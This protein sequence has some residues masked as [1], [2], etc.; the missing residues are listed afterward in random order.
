MNLYEFDAAIDAHRRKWE[1][2]RYIAKR[3]VLSGKDK[4]AVIGY[5]LLDAQGREVMS[6]AWTSGIAESLR[7]E[8]EWER[9]SYTWLDRLRENA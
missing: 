5:T 9:A 4:D 2:V 8:F 3:T 7:E 6:C 1:R